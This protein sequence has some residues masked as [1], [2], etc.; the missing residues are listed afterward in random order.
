MPSIDVFVQDADTGQSTTYS[1]SQSEVRLGRSP[2]N[3]LVFDL[4]YVSSYHVLIQFDGVTGTV[5]DLGSRNG[6][7]LDSTRLKKDVPV[8]ITVRSVIRIGNLAIR[9]GPSG[10]AFSAVSV[11]APQPGYSAAAGAVGAISAPPKGGGPEM[12][13]VYPSSVVA[14]FSSLTGPASPPA[15]REPAAEPRR[16]FP[17]G[18]AP[19]SLPLFRTAPPPGAARPDSVSDAERPLDGA[20]VARAACLETFARGFLEM[21][22]GYQAF[23]QEMG[24]V[25]AAGNSPLHHSQNKDEILQYLLDPA[26]DRRSRLAEL[27]KM[28]RVLMTHEIAL[29]A[30]VK[31]GLKDLLRELDPELV[32]EGQPKSRGFLSREDKNMERYREHYERVTE[33]DG[34]SLLFG[35]SFR[36]AYA[37]IVEEN[38]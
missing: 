34:H 37:R 10:M 12:A 14:E 23:G 7:V 28:F 35:Q 27:E 29:L 33:D 4:P 17:L 3:N 21:R 32:V 2:V 11:G 38:S 24:L 30:G 8:P 31:A 9:V 6:T 25:L 5:C 13:P 26:V 36:Q 18:S 19:S 20:Q 22:R 15:G 16:V 1:F